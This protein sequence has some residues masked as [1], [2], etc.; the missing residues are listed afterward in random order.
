MGFS[1]DGVHLATT[2]VLSFLVEIK[3][4]VKREFRIQTF[5]WPCF[6][7]AKSIWV[8]QTNSSVQ[9]STC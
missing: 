4:E 7:G 8:L 9:K 5:Q 1:L 3:L 6:R 2:L